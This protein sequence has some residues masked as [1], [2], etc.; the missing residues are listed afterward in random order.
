MPKDVIVTTPEDFAWRRK[1]AGT[2][3]RPA[4]REDRVLYERP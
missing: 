1:L 2:I 4:A 3:E